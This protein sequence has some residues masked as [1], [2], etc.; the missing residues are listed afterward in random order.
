MKEINQL[1]EKDH[2]RILLKWAGGVDCINL[3]LVGNVL[4]SQGT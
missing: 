3:A 4:T 1:E 2:G